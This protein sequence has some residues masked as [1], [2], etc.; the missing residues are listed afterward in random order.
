MK[1]FILK[2][3]NLTKEYP[4]V[5]ALNN[6]S[7]EF[8]KGKIHSL[9]GENGAGKST[10]IKLITGAVDKTSGKIYYKGNEIE[11]NSPI[12]SLNKGIIPVYQ[13]L[14]M[15]PTLSIVENIFYGNEKTNGLILD[16]KYMLKK[17]RELL[18]EVGLN[19][20]P[21][22]KIRDMGIGNQQ[23]VEISKALVRNV[24]VLILD[25]PT[26]SL[27]DN[28]IKNLFHIIN[29]LKTD[30]VT[31]IYISH[32]LDEVLEISDT[33]TVLRDG[34]VIDSKSPTEL[35]EEMLV[36]LMVGRDLIR[37]KKEKEK[38]IVS[39]RVLE[40]K[41]V[42][43]NKIKDISFILLKGEIL[44]IAGLIGSGR[45]E[46]AEAIFGVDEILSG[47]VF[48]GGKQKKIK[49][50]RD[51]IEEN[52]A[53]ITE[54]RKSLG[55]LLDLSVLENVTY[56]SLENISKIG[57]IDKRKEEKLVKNILEKLQVKYS[58]LGEKVLNLS[59][60]NQQKI[61]IAKWLLSNASIFIF[62]E[63]TRGIDVGAKEEIYNILRSLTEEGKSIIM[64]SSEMQEVINISDRI[65]VMSNGHIVSEYKSSEITS[66]KI[67]IDSASLL[68][69]QKNG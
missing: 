33:I 4:G 42:N 62:D 69:E 21:E 14:N 61:V 27:T 49:S 47:E 1:E 24:E 39:Q 16:K 38:E 28:E 45:T 26:A 22:T 31:I 36:N 56:S 48:I 17:T 52:I 11:N 12:N 50:P 2:L 5:V 63:P 25:E 18:T 43:T 13:E 51:A 68:K 66:E 3:E 19:I 60:G 35:D 54:D 37:N 29:K 30:G 32:R 53:F 34:K 58:T 59:G 8:E 15:I 65:L 55:L 10:L 41:N 57:V 9:V 6:V 64:I 67:F 40:F 44:G 23:L 20:S 46:L 7:I